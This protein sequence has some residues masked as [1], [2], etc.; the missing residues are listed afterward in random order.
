VV[1]LLDQ[2][3][4]GLDQRNA[5]AQQHGELPGGN[6]HVHRCDAS[7]QPPKIDVA[8]GL[9]RR[10]RLLEDFRRQD[11]IPL[12]HGAERFGAVGVSGTLDRLAPCVDAFVRVDAHALDLGGLC[13]GEHL[14]HARDTR[15]DLACAVFA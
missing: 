9:F 8:R 12:E 4:Q 1:E 11:S 14:F 13:R 2:R 10:L 5:S 15:H 3:A 6:G 7:K